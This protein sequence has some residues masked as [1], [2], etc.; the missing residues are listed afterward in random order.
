MRRWLL[1]L[2]VAFTLYGLP[3]SVAAEPRFFPQTGITVDEPFRTYWESHGGLTL[4]GF[5]IS[6]LVE[7]PDEDGISRPVQYFERARFELH[8]DAPPSERVL[9]SRLGLRSLTARGI[10]WHTFPSTGAQDGCQFFTATGRNVCAPFDAFWSQWGGL[11]IFGLPLM[12]A[13]R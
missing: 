4:F 6:P 12:P 11:A 10:D 9:L 7:E 8:L 2:L 1:L 13:Q 3:P 5:P